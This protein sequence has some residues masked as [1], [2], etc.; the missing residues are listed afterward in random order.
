IVTP[1]KRDSVWGAV[2]LAKRQLQVS[3]FKSRRGRPGIFTGEP[4]EGPALPSLASLELSPTEQRNPRSLNLD[5]TSLVKAIVLMLSEEEKIPRSILAERKNI[6]RAVKL[7][8]RS[9]KRGG[10]LFYV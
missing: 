1:L 7:I 8:V 9:F 3:G 2:Q 5:R 6:E 4:H 10:R